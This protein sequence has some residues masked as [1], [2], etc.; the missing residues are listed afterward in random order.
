MTEGLGG[1]GEQL[2]RK[3][4]ATRTE[5]LLGPSSPPGYPAMWVRLNPRKGDSGSRTLSF[6]EG[7]SAPSSSRPRGIAI[8]LESATLD[9][10]PVRPG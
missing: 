2:G 1:L 10:G 8:L 5:D 9:Q 7:Q 3:G 4:E 6:E